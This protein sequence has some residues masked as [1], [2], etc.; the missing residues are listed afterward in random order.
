MCVCVCVCVCDCVC[1]RVCVCVYSSTSRLLRHTKKRGAAATRGCGRGGA[2][3]LVLCAQSRRAHAC[4][5]ASP[6][7][8]IRQLTCCVAVAFRMRV[9]KRHLAL[10]SS[11]EGLMSA[12]GMKLFNECL[13][14]ARHLALALRAFL[15]SASGMRFSSCSGAA[16]SLCVDASRACVLV[17]ACASQV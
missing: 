16:C 6:A 14:H 17:R 3:G 8:S 7:V 1:V 5:Q 9:C 4:L 15:M 11:F 13:W 2:R 10:A 12:S